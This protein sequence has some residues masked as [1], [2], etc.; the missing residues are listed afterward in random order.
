MDIGPKSERTRRPARDDVE[1]ECAQ[2]VPASADIAPR[3]LAWYDRERR[4]L[5]WRFAPGAKADPYK[6]W[7]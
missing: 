5:P 6:V 2:M 3:M 4:H 1:H 7:L